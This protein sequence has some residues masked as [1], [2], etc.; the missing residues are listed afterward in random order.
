MITPR[1]ALISLDIV[2][3]KLKS[4]YEWLKTQPNV[5]VNTLKQRKEILDLIISANLALK[6]L[7]YFDEFVLLGQILMVLN[8]KDPTSAGFLIKFFTK[9]YGNNLSLCT[10]NPYIK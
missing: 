2:E 7:P 8:K 9:P 6:D 4:S 1:E 5:N 3:E 10:F